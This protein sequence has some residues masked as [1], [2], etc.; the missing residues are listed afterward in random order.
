[1]FGR[2][3]VVKRDF[4][5]KDDLFFG[6]YNLFFGVRKEMNC[7]NSGFDFGVGKKNILEKE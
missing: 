5:D 7:R 6:S 1:M 4:K 2:R 3:V